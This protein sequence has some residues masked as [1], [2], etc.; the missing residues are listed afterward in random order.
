MATEEQ[1]KLAADRKYLEDLQQKMDVVKGDHPGWYADFEDIDP[2]VADRSDVEQLLRT[3]PTDWAVGYVSGILAVRQ[4]LAL[5]T[6][7]GF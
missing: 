2:F 1:T 3:A 4:Q 6:G 5:V 7:R